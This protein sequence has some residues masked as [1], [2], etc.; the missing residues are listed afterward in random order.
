MYAIRSYY[1]PEAISA[2]DV[3]MLVVNYRNEP[4][5]LRV[6]DPATNGPDGKPGTQTA[7]KGGDLA[8]ALASVV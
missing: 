6:F 1:G 5:G 4:V 2:D 3:G 7:G 8:F